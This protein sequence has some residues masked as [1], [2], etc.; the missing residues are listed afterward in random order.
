MSGSILLPALT[1]PESKSKEQS[2]EFHA[3]TETQGLHAGCTDRVYRLVY[4]REGITVSVKCDMALLKHGYEDE[5]S[6]VL[7][8]LHGSAS[9]LKAVLAAVSSYEN[10]ELLTGDAVLHVYREHNS[11]LK[12]R[13]QKT[14][15]GKYNA[16]MWNERIKEDYVVVLPD[17]IPLKSWKRFL[18]GR[19]IPYL[20]EWIPEIQRIL[21]E[22]GLIKKLVG[23]GGIS[24]WFWN[25]SDD[26]VCDLIVRK[27]WR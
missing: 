24:G 25:C 7:I 9:E 5:H 10:A 6:I 1:P 27:I 13:L 8:S 18:D 19:K 23:L 21:A 2:I 16:V 15:Y 26:E 3:N 14:G 20:E 17:E 11:N 22:E 12:A 4:R